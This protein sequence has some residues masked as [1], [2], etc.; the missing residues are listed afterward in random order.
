M[1][2]SSS[3][4]F[5]WFLLKA[6]TSLSPPIASGSRS[7]EHRALTERVKELEAALGRAHMGMEFLKLALEEKPSLPRRESK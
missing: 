3:G 2:T 6:S 4:Q 5:S 1:R 7:D